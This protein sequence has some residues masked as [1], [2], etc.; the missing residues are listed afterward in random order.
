MP[1]TLQ[2][3]IR[4]LSQDDFGELAYEVLRHVFAIHNELG[5]YFDESIY[6]RE[7]A[8]RMPNVRLEE[9]IDV[10]FDSFRKRYFLDVLVGKWRHLRIQVHNGP[11]CF[12]PGSAFE[13]PAIVRR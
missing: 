9:P 2:T 1:V 6:K 5:R 12:A 3:P 8:F 13:L 10:V 4:N 7:L 11:C